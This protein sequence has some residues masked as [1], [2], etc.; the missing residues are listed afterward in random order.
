MAIRTTTATPS[1]TTIERGRRRTIPERQTA[2]AIL[3]VLPALVLG[4]FGYIHMRDGAATD[5]AVPVPV[6]MI[7]QVSM[8]RA[9][10]I[11]AAAALSKA[12]PRNGEAGIARAEALL[13]A[14]EPNRPSAE[15][16]LARALT[17][18]PASARGWTL[19]SEAALPHDRKL[20]ARALRRALLLGPRDY[21]LMEAR[22][23]D[24]ALLWRDLDHDT[25][26]I[27]LGQVRML[28]REQSLRKQLLQLLRTPEGMAL[29]ARAFADRD[30]EIR[31]M[32]RWLSRERQEETP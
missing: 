29:T 6:Y 1:T 26:A 3:L 14:G 10:Y 4:V 8:P 16:L 32:N 30:D 20:A 27:A 31:A 11:D 22:A 24:A 21:W 12:D 17:H 23:Q 13:R 28:W 5:A 18:Q 19:L 15:E 2:V 9:A 7:A 25:Q